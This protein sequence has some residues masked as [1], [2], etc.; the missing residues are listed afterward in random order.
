MGNTFY[1][2]WEVIL[3]EFLQKNMNDAM[4][5]FASFISAFGEELFMLIALGFMYWVWDKKIGLKMG[6]N[7]MLLS[8][9]YPIFKNIVLR[10]RPYFDHENIK[11]LKIIDSSADMYD[12]AAQGYSFPSGHSATSMG[13]FGSFAYFIKNKILLILAVLMPLVVGISRFC[14]GMHYPTDVICGWAIG[15]ISIFLIPALEKKFKNPKHLYYLIFA[16]ACIG[17]LFA[18]T[19]DYYRNIGMLL[20]LLLGTNFE[21]KYVNFNKT[22]NPLA[23][24]LRVAGGIAIYYGLEALLV[25]PFSKE[26]L[27]SAT[28]LQFLIRFIR[29]TIIYFI[30]FGVYPM[31]FGKIIKEK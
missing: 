29:Y 12:P 15:L 2:Q 23:I 17:V 4:V 19:N 24:I 26:L 21:E 13:I 10:R 7:L 22:R 16:V 5:N 11:C 30:D 6:M 9:A 1:F 20:G 8:L 14:L 31:L 18:K 25:L 28:S 27:S 3:M